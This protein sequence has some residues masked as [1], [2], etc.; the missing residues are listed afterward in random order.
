[1]RIVHIEK[2]L[3]ATG[4]VGSYL[5]RL[6]ELQR[7]RGHEVTHFGCVG[8]QGPAEMPRLEDFTAAK[9]PR[10]LWR[11]IHNADAAAKLHAF[12]RRRPADVAHLHNVYHHL[13][14]SILPVLA[15][16]GV[17]IVMTV[18]DYR[19]ACPTKHFLRPDGPCTRCLPNKFYHAASSRCAALRGAALGLESFVQRLLRRYFR[20]IS[21]F[22]CPTE[23]MRTVLL[24]SGVPAKK[25]VLCRNVIEPMVLPGNTPQHP[26]EVLLAGRLSAEKM[27]ELALELAERL[28][29][30]RLVVAGDGPLL[31]ELQEKVRSRNLA[32]VTLAGHVDHKD[33]GGYLARAAAVVVTS[34]WFEN[35]PQIMLEAMA[36]GR[37]VIVPDHPPL[38]EWVRDGHTGRVFAPGDPGS[39]ATVAREVLF[40]GNGRAGMER[41]GKA[42]VERRHDAAA[43][44]ARL[45]ALYEEAIVRCGLR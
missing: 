26:G 14:P 29:E 7:S 18:H 8:P 17:G 41:A 13:S 32:N 43:L 12:L 6:T 38:R 35:S 40:D 33:L 3:P 21:F 39:L 27:P 23:F 11:M 37:C 25:A 20:W 45:E 42:L 16:H 4:G 34:R 15:R 9:G 24:R 22:L 44:L 1:M 36:A 19:L 5:R 31:S 2:F 28:P 30:A 10:A